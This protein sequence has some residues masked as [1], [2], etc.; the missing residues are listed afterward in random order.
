MQL[1]LNKAWK[2][3]VVDSGLRHFAMQR[4]RSGLLLV[5]AGMLAIVS[6][7][8]SSVISVLTRMLPFPDAAHAGEMLTSLAMFAIVF[9]AILKVMPD[10]ELRWSDVWAGGRTVHRAAIRDREILDRD[11]PGARRK[12]QRVWCGGIARADSDVDLLFRAHLSA[13]RRVDPGL[14]PPQ[15]PRGPAKTRR[16]SHGIGLNNICF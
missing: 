10:V 8:A 14:G 1:Q 13:R 4:R 9:A 2:V 11:L 3:K 6:V 16:G 15:G 12:D 7:A 5:G